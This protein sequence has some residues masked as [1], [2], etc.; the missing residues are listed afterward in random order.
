M[1]GS[2]P[3]ALL[4]LDSLMRSAERRTGPFLTIP[5]SLPRLDLQDLSPEEVTAMLADFDEA[6]VRHRP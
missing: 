4:A 1:T 6:I 2:P 5:V 3:G